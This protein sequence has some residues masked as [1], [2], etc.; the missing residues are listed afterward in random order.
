[1]YILS[2]PTALYEQAY[3]WAR[4]RNPSPLFLEIL[5]ILWNTALNNGV[6]PVLVVVQCAKETA[7]CK[8]SG[9]LDASY[10][11]TCGLKNTKGGL[12][13]EADAHMKFKSWEEGA[14]AQVQHLCLYAGQYGYPVTNPVDPRHFKYL[15]GKCPTVES[16][17]NNWAGE[18]YGKDLVAMCFE[19][20]NT[21]V[22]QTEVDKL[23]LELKNKNKD[24]DNLQLDIKDKIKKID[25]LKIKLKKYEDIKSKLEEIIKSM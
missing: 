12:D 7:Y 8:F 2:K 14:L 19:V 18:N 5:P 20:E 4:V 22:K 13:T 1:M 16:L 9:V 10:R 15:F 24:I 17:S 11:N 21:T 3:E 23:K 25:D 6:N